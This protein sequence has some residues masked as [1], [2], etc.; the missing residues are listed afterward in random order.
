MIAQSLEDA[1]KVAGDPVK[2]LRSTKYNV[3]APA[4]YSPN[5]VMPQLPY[6]FTTWEMEGR[7]WRQS[8]ALLDLSHH[9]F[10]VFISGR[11]SL[12]LLS[13]LACNKL[14]NSTP[15]RA[16]QIVCCSQEGYLISDGILFHLGKDEFSAYGPRIANWIKY[17]AEISGLDVKTTLDYR[18][19]VYANGHSNTRP[20]FRY[21]IQGPNAPKLIEKLNGG[22]VDVKFFHMTEM[23][24]GGHKVRALRHGMAGAP[25]LEVWGPWEERDDV[26]EAILEAGEEFG[27]VLV[28]SMAY[29]VANAESGWLPV[30]VP[31]IFS[32]STKKYREWLPNNGFEG[33]TR[34]QGTY[35]SDR[36]EDY[37]RTPYD[38]GYGHI[39]NFEHDFVGREAVE[40]HSKDQKLKKV[41]LLWNVDDACELFARMLSPDG[42]DYR[43]LHLPNMNE[44]NLSYDTVTM[45]G[46]MVGTA[47]FTAYTPNEHSILSLCTVDR[48]LEL[49]EEV[50]LNWGEAGGG[51]GDRTFAPTKTAMI[52][53]IVSPVPYSKVVREEYVGREGWRSRK[54]A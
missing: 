16:H 27:L 51:F 36:V 13:R 53:A 44:G 7:A 23:T 54:M 2:L 1:L 28:G 22:P 39:V 38:M 25:G 24:I 26:R 33:L 21:Q 18:S 30:V 32:E 31:A 14:A 9:M 6:Q 45:G 4:A 29:L 46:K 3:K 48:S 43:F 41:T 12:K 34:L 20:N 47:H 37:Y 35:Y 52:R 50:V 17:Q 8:V 11:D 42:S 5:L 49:G 10:G 19:P 40:K 15:N